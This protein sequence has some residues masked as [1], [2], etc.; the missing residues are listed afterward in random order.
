[1]ANLNL[2]QNNLSQE[3]GDKIK[4][5]VGTAIDIIVKLTGGKSSFGKNK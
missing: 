5:I 4:N 3:E 1:M 2:N